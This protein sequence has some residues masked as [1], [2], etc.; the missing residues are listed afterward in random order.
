[1]KETIS[2]AGVKFT[3]HSCHDSRSAAKAR[4]VSTRQRQGIKVRVLKNGK[5]FCLYTGSKLKR[6][7]AKKR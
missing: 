1:M 6:Q 5:K 3:S 2:I 4:A 7:I